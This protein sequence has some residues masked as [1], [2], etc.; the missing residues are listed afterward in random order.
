[1][2]APAPGPTADGRRPS[3][4]KKVWASLLSAVAIAAL[5]Y[6]MVGL[7]SSTT[8]SGLLLAGVLLIGGGASLARVAW[9]LYRGW[10]GVYSIAEGRTPDE[11]RALSREL[12]R[13]QWLTAAKF[14][15]CL[16]PAYLLVALLLEDREAAIGAA[17]LV[18]MTSGGLG[19]LSWV[20]GRRDA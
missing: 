11:V 16:V 17:A 3:A 7:L 20:S 4:T 6:G 5:L 2:T 9:R 10:P 13:R 14:L 8:L 12:A 19:L 1:M 18:A 15:L